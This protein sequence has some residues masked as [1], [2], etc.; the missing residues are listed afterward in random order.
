MKTTKIKNL[1]IVESPAKAKKIESFLGSDYTVMASIGHIRSIAKKAGGGVKPIDTEHDFATIYEIDPEKRKVVKE[2]KDAVKQAET[3]WLA[4]DEDREGEA[5]AW[6][7]CQVLG[8]NPAKTNRITYHEITK[9]AI[10][11][12]LAHPHTVDMNLVY[13]QQARQILD[14]LVGFELSPVVWR[15][16]PGGKSAG[17]VQ[18]PAVRLLVEREREIEHL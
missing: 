16:V 18:S 5:I 17:R 8:L 12:A 1:I 4:S 2:L 15:K 14:R 11:E 7:L 9:E 6:H 13:A 3:I 10:T